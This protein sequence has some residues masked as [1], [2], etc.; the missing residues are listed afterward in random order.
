MPVAVGVTALLF[1]LGHGLLLS[2][3]AFVWF[4]IVIALLR[5]RTDSIYPA[6]LVHCTFNAIGMIAPLFL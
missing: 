2:L 6:F 5:L 3:A 4:G 1:G